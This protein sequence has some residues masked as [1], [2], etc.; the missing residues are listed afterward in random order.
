MEKELFGWSHPVIVVN[1]SMFRQRPVM[2][3]IPLGSILELI[4][5]SIFINNL[6]SGIKY[7]PSNFTDD[8]KLTSEVD[9]IEGRDATHKDLS[10][11]EK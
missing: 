4:L 6:E 5:F 9:R 10:R 11:L 7:V 2:S 1:G 3:G 8:T